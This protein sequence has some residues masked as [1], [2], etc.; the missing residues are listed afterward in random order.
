MVLWVIWKSKKSDIRLIKIKKHGA[1]KKIIIHVKN[2]IL[3]LQV[4]DI[5][6]YNVLASLAVLKEFDLSFKK[7]IKTF[8]SL[9]PYDG[10]GKIFKIKRFTII[11]QWI[12]TYSFTKY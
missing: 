11:L 5:H 9:E 8:E 3:E 6:I 1:I 4:K 10:R 7:N 2:E 12:C